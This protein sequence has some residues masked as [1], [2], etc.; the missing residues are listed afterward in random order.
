LEDNPA[1]Q[2]LPSQYWVN[3]HALRAVKPIEATNA[4]GCDLV[5]KKR[6]DRCGFM[7]GY[8]VLPVE[9]VDEDSSMYWCFA[10]A[11]RYRQSRTG[12][13]DNRTPHFDYNSR[14]KEQQQQHQR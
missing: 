2:C 7:V 9:F 3:L 13:N 8:S 10:S 12:T 6:I 14:Q 4:L 1:N 11:P 5:S